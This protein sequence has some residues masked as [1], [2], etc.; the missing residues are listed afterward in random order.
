[1][2]ICTFWTKPTGAPSAAFPYTLNHLEGMCPFGVLC[3][4]ET[5]TSVD[6]LSEHNREKA[7]DD[8]MSHGKTFQPLHS[9]SFT[10][11]NTCNKE[12]SSQ[13]EAL[14]CN[15]Y[16]SLYPTRIAD[17]KEESNGS[18][19]MSCTKASSVGPARPAAGSSGRPCILG[20]A[21]VGRLSR[22]H[23]LGTTHVDFTSGNISPRFL[24]LIP[25]L[26]Q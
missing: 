26:W 21:H 11:F 7:T 14:L 15:V 25:A 13:K 1:M 12:Q 2:L 10:P 20:A 17:K 24:R 23:R 22:G 3:I 4:R 18:P 9:I 16:L 6:R 19:V 8:T 5:L